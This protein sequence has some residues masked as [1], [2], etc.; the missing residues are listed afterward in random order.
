MLFW[1]SSFYK[2]KKSKNGVFFAGFVGS[3]FFLL[4]KGASSVSPVDPYG[5][6]LERVRR[7]LGTAAENGQVHFA[8][9]SS[10]STKMLR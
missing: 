2:K 9:P 10:G 6:A 1:G 3:P 4:A 5:R 8:V 7:P